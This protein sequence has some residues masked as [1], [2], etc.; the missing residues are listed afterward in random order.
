MVSFPRKYTFIKF[1]VQL[2]KICIFTYREGFRNSRWHQ[3]HYIAE[4]DIEFIIFLLLVQIS[5]ITGI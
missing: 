1:P 2:S 5:E 3:T 4:D